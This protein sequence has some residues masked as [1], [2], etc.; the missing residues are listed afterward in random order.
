MLL[1]DNV[2]LKRRERSQTVADPTTFN[3]KPAGVCERES[4]GSYMVAAGK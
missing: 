2:L 3:S 4:Q 1:D